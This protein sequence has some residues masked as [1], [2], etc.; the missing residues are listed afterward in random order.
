M[1]E[2]IFSAS[3]QQAVFRAALQA[4]SFPGRCVA[5]PASVAQTPVHRAL[6]A[7]LLD[8]EVSL[9]DPQNLLSAEADWPFLEAR[10]IDA[11]QADFILL[12]GEKVHS[13]KPRIGTLEEPEKSASLV[14][15][16]GQMGA[17]DGLE[18]KLTGPGIQTE[19]RLHVEGL[20][21]EWLSL[22]QNWN[23]AFPMGVDIF[24]A[25]S[26]GIVALPRTTQIE[27]I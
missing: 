9:A 12:G 17:N 5:L 16:V 10:A 26:N 11:D 1:L 24:L 15:I 13:I 25:G 22:R 20:A 23:T 21:R 2:P 18:L 6:L 8:A 7:A 14:L 3:V 19:Q 27:V 4:Q